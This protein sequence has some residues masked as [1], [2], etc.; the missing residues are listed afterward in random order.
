MSVDPL[1]GEEMMIIEINYGKDGK[2]QRGEILV[3]FGDDPVV[4]AQKF[5]QDHKLKKSAVDQIYKRILTTIAEFK[6]TN[7]ELDL[8]AP[9]GPDNPEEEFI[10][11]SSC[12]DGKG[13]DGVGRVAAYNDFAPSQ[14]T[15]S[16]ERLDASPIPKLKPASG[17]GNDNGS[18]S[19]GPETNTLEDSKE[20]LYNRMKMAAKHTGKN[21]EHENKKGHHSK[22]GH[23]SKHHGKHHRHSK[24]NTNSGVSEESKSSDD[25]GHMKDKALHLMENLPVSNSISLSVGDSRNSSTYNTDPNSAHERLYK[26]AKSQKEKREYLSAKS[27]EK[28]SQYLDQHKFTMNENSRAIMEN[29][30]LR[31]NNESGDYLHILHNEGVKEIERQKKLEAEKEKHKDLFV[32]DTR[33]GMYDWSCA[34]CGHLHSIGTQELIRKHEKKEKYVCDM[35]AFEKDDAIAPFKPHIYAMEQHSENGTLNHLLHR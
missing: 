21:H 26:T 29:N 32:F 4:L 27:R 33:H 24:T 31:V 15:S 22:H 16:L 12:N 13:D 3:K 35:C 20:A 5:V 17:K 28:E 6:K 34:K 2:D 11:S 9:L 8:Q 19:N 25:Y 10:P 23:G 18:S 1:H 14:S 30:R 7:S